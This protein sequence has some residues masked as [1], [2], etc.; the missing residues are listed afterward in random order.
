MATYRLPPPACA[1][2]PLA[3]ALARPKLIN[4]SLEFGPENLLQMDKR[5]QGNKRNSFLVIKTKD[6][7]IT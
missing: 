3:H 7:E 1:K 4:P 6:S 5:L 2:Q